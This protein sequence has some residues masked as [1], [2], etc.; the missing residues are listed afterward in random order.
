ML[1]WN[2]DA[3]TLELAVR[4]LVGGR[5]ELGGLAMSA[6]ARARAGGQLHRQLQADEKEEA[7]RSAEV[8]WRHTV[9]VE[10]WRVVVTARVDGLVEDID[11]ITLVE[12]IKSV[13][14]GERALAEAP[15]PEP[16]RRQL[17]VYLH[18]AV[19]AQLPSPVGRL[20]LVSLA[21]GSQRCVQERPDPAIGSWLHAWLRARI[22]SRELWLSWRHQRRERTVAFPYRELRPGQGEILTATV[23]AVARGQV[24]AISAPTGLGKTA[25]ALVGALREAFRT[26]LGVFWAT[27]RGTQRWIL[28]DT[29]RRLTD[30]GVALR[31]VVVPSRAEACAACARGDCIGTAE[32]ADLGA[33]AALGVVS[34]DQVS[35]DAARQGCCPWALAVEYAAHLADVVVA[36]LNYAFEPD[37]YLRPCFGAGAPRQW[38]VMVDEAHQLPERARGWASVRLD[39]SLFDKLDRSLP[40]ERGEPFR[41]LGLVARE[42][43]QAEAESGEPRRWDIDASAVEDTLEHYDGLAYEHARIREDDP[44]N[45]PGDDPWRSFGQSLFRLATYA[46]REGEEVVAVTDGNSLQLVCRDAAFLLRDRV[47][48]CA[49]VVATS[50]TLHPTWFW[51]AR[52]GIDDA[53]FTELSVPSNF[54]ADHRLVLL[55]RNVSTAW[56]DRAKERERLV[57][58]LDRC[59]AAIP[60]NIAIFFG[61]FDQLNDLGP[62]LVLGGRDRIVQRPGM[63]AA[64][65]TEVAAALARPSQ[66]LLA[67]LGGVFAESVDLPAGALAAAIIVGPG[68]PPPELETKLLTEWYER[69]YDDGFG[70]ASVHAGMTRVVQAAGRVVRSADERGAVVLLCRRFLQHELLAY[71]PSEWQPQPTSRPWEELEAFFTAPSAATSPHPPAS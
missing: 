5:A 71:L 18:I 31:A 17:L 65:R 9:E 63:S 30:G 37:I 1:R 12:E 67:V 19:A 4:D 51:R 36:D 27:A 70:L 38:A 34:P 69:R 46:D 43:L 13:G 6:R 39:A 41:A 55:A 32:L 35:E 45:G 42:W 53:R 44:W 3:H 22:R 62:A 14:L 50:A 26:D 8:T 57:D 56:K 66:V 16:W 20:R 47:A 68:F 54:P 28:L 7:G 15:I 40:G 2:D 11:G 61:S 64:A 60:G 52:V 21:D 24:L 49:A 58:V 25:P 48:A 59:V 33:L 23:Q 10:G 29:V